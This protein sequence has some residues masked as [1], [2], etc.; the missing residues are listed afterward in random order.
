[1]VPRVIL[2][3]KGRNK[4]R[5]WM[6]AQ[7]TRGELL[8][9]IEVGRLLRLPIMVAVKKDVEIETEAA[10]GVVEE[11]AETGAGVVVVAAAA[12]EITM[13]ASVVGTIETIVGT[14]VGVVVVTSGV[15]TGEA[16][17]GTE[18]AIDVVEAG[19]EAEEGARNQIMWKLAHNA[20]CSGDSVQLIEFT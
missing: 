5:G 7:P 17:I 10:I 2:P 14:M 6:E 20:Q 15:M 13:I 9:A 3:S 19:E 8:R 1:M 4:G 16:A 11:K 18:E 12:G